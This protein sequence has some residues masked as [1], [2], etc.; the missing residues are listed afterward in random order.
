M[1]EAS[2]RHSS[3]R[4]WGQGSLWAGFFPLALCLCF[5][6]F[7]VS[8]A[9]AQWTGVQNPV[10][11]HQGAYAP[12]GAPIP[13]HMLQQATGYGQPI[14]YEY[15]ALAAQGESVAVGREV[16]QAADEVIVEDAWD[17]MGLVRVWANGV[18]PRLITVQRYS[19][20][21]W[22]FNIDLLSLERHSLSE[23]PLYYT[24][25]PS[26]DTFKRNA[27]SGGMRISA[28]TDLFHSVELELAWLGAINW[29]GRP[30]NQFDWNVVNNG[31]GHQYTSGSLT[32]P[33]GTAIIANSN[34]T[35]F[36]STLNTFEINSRFKWVGTTN[37]FTGAWILGPRYIRFTESAR[38][39]N[40][41]GNNLLFIPA[42]GGV[43]GAVQGQSVRTNAVND[44]VGFQ[45]GGEWFWAVSRGVMIGGNL[46]GGIYG[47]HAVNKSQII[48][49]NNL[50]AE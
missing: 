18:P 34:F 25:T 8:R 39:K 48:T 31:R 23:R 2:R 4:K 7:S 10:F 27:P 26:V 1:E 15:Q 50:R 5:L 46:K 28:S 20:H 13:G 29:E 32:Q 38:V 6:A 35:H 11:L 9:S 41:N 33:G 40:D 12:Q 3:S 16:Q 36:S 14:N 30:T 45:A 42:T 37:A 17:P 21:Y 44:L 43:P 24:A 22:K 47:N 19:D 49:T